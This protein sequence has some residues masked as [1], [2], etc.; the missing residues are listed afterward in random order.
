MRTNPVTCFQNHASLSFKAKRRDWL[1]LAIA[2]TAAPLF[3]Q[4]G[5]N[6]SAK[7]LHVLD[8]LDPAN[9]KLSHR[10]SIRATDDD[11]LFLKQI[12]LRFFRAEIPN[13]A[14]LAEIAQARDRFAS[15]GITMWSAAH[16]GHTT[17][18]IA[19]GRPGAARDQDIE[20]CLEI[21]RLFGRLGVH[22]AV[23]DWLPANTFTTAIVERRGYRTREFSL[24][25]FRSRFDKTRFDR[26]YSSQE[27][28]EAFTYFL[29]AVLPVAEQANV[30]LAMHPS[31]P[32]VVETMNGVGRI[33][34]GYEDYRRAE[35][36]AGNSSSWG[37]R[38]CVG[39][40]AEGGQDMGEN[41]FEMIHDFGSRG[42]IY[43]VDFRNVSSPLPVFQ[44]TFPDE[45]YMD[46]YQVMRALREVK[47]AGTMVPDHVP[48]LA[49]DE[50]LVQRAGTA[51][52]IAHMR[53][54]LRRANEEVG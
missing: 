18:D 19:L 5:A 23:L 34:R 14:S 25:D 7:P 2:G 20:R 42:K 31:D 21:I 15:Y 54:L 47:Y 28:W 36:L 29:R 1:K 11:L 8:E 48:G 50:G 6:Q 9:I 10:V 35:E 27:I 37:V 40:W 53:A 12:G 49:G 24:P 46:M 3:G 26:E 13:D 30:K 32:P 51:Y 52:C 22:V 4:S 44:E 43:D 45:G 41:V 38:L 39:T 33:F 16:Y 17:L